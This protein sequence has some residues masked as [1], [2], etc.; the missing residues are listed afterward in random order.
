M[1]EAATNFSQT[2]AASD[3]AK[4]LKQLLSQCTTVAK[5]RRIDEKELKTSK[6]DIRH[7][8]EN[9]RKAIVAKLDTLVKRV[10]NDVEKIYRKEQEKIQSN[11][12]DLE[13]MV[14][15]MEDKLADIEIAKAVSADLPLFIAVQG[16]REMHANTELALTEIHNSAHKVSLK[17]SKS[18]IQVTNLT[19]GELLLDKHPYDLI[20]R[21]DGQVKQQQLKAKSTCMSKDSKITL[22][23]EFNIRG[24]DDGK[25]CITGLQAL[26]DNFIVI[27]DSYN[28]CVKLTSPAY[29]ILDTFRLNHPPFDV[30]LFAGSEVAVTSP[31]TAEIYLFDVKGR[32]YIEQ[33]SSIN[34]GFECYGITTFDSHFIVTCV[35]DK[36]VKM[37]DINGKE[38]WT[39]KTDSSGETLFAW[40]WYV[41]VHDKTHEMYISDR[42]KNL[43]VQAYTNGVYRKS[44]YAED[45][46][47]RGMAFDGV[48][49][50]L[51]CHFMTDLLE[52]KTLGIFEET[53]VIGTKREGIKHPQCITFLHGMP[54]FVVSSFNSD[55]FKVYQ[56]R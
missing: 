42:N 22:H 53:S 38:K 33:K 10:L 19:V 40:P 20:P 28:N 24:P 51:V 31:E 55:S 1:G 56:L 45:S 17:L 39:L 30:T 12:S 32:K 46:G 41:V 37:I 8:V 54:Q 18:D 43:I 14:R 26:L 47:P 29:N 6:A 27:C 48:G 7:Y 34:L 49:N 5:E 44:H 3:W 35:P 15:G 23:G 4:I 13:K 11:L 36:C 25:C 21:S 50:L 9:Y 52:I 16:A 2:D